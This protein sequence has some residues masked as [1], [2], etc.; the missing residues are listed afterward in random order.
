MALLAPEPGMG[1]AGVVL[2]AGSHVIISTSSTSHLGV[3]A[4]RVHPRPCVRQLGAT[5]QTISAHSWIGLFTEVLYDTGTN[6]SQ[7][8]HFLELT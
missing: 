2:L 6:T 3:S 5:L 4:S 1:T 7:F 8:L